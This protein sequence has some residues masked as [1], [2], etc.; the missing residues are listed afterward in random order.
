MRIFRE[1]GFALRAAFARIRNAPGSFIFNVLVIALALML[2][3]AGL[4]VLDNVRP[5]S[6][7]IAVE[8]EISVFLSTEIPGDRIQVIGNEIR[9]L[10]Q[11]EQLKAKVEFISRDKA[12]DALRERAGLSDVVATLGNNPLPDA[13]VLKLASAE[14]A[15]GASR[16]EKLAVGLR[17]LSGVETVQLDSDWVR[18]LAALM[19]LATTVLWLL[20]ATL[21]GVVLAVV[22][23]TIRLQVM[24]QSEEIAVL[25][26]L[27]A[28]DG[29]VSRPF[30]YTGA[31]LGVA[32]GALA[33]AGVLFALWLLNGSVMPLAQLYGS[34]FR[35]GPL[36]AD[37]TAMLLA[38]CAALGIV[39]AALSVRRSLRQPG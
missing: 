11:R 4:T 18:R 27:G 19:T 12:L 6:Q 32:A 22:F 7:G 28:T 21:C 8:P 20:A 33:L 17:K 14:D 34:P 39:G 31:L 35:L 23:N 9:T 16:I 1:H 2:P 38:G 36:P 26:L 13:Y 5:V 24:T 3:L 30:Y 29:F 10:V 25:R 15:A 37:T